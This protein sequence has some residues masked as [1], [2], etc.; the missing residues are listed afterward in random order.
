M[1]MANIDA[2]FDFMFTSPLNED[3]VRPTSLSYITLN[4][5]AYFLIFIFRLRLFHPT[6]CFILLTFALDPVAFRNIFY[7]E[8]SG[9]RR[10]S[11][12]H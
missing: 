3:G 9:K 8:K 12:S 5:Q 10:G 1:K 4:K 6:S 11:V 2:V 7:G